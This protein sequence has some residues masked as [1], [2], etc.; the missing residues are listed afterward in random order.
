MK[1]TVQDELI[2][3]VMDAKPTPSGAVCC[4]AARLEL[5]KTPG[6]HR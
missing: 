3:S 4:A 5:A 1:N 2:I 6:D